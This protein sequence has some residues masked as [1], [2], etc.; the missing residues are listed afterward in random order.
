M[1]NKVQ[2]GAISI[3][4][5]ELLLDMLDLE[6]DY[7]DSQQTSPVP[8][9]WKLLIL[10]QST[11]KIVSPV[12]KVSELRDQGVTLYLQLLNDGNIG[13]GERE[14]LREVPAVYFVQ[15][16][17]QNITQICTVP[18]EHFITTLLSHIQSFVGHEKGSLRI[19]LFELCKSITKGDARVTCTNSSR[20]GIG[21]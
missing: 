7:V 5:L 11:S 14:R 6:K 4:I 16:T 1:S 2:L 20:L 9:T 21:G 19:V 17:L 10:D 13:N 12:L 8:L 18:N 3:I 15:P